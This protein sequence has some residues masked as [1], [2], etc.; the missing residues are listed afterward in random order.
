MKGNRLFVVVV[1]LISFV[2][3]TFVLY[4]P[5]PRF[6]TEQ[7][8]AVRAASYIEAFS[9]EPHSVFD[10]EAH[11]DVRQYL[12][13]TV[14]SFVGE[15]NVT[16][17][18]YTKEEL[19]H[20][21]D[22]GIQN[23]LATIPGE[24]ETGILIVAHYDSRGH[25]GRSGELGRSYGAADDGYGV[26]TM[27][28]IARLYGDQ[29]LQN[30][31]YLLFTDAEETGL[32]GAEM[33]AKE[34]WLMDKVGFVINLEARGVDGPAY[35]FETS[36]N[37]RKV[38][39]FYRQA[40][41]P[42]SY[43][44]A[45]AVYTVMPNSTD[46]TEFLAIGKQGVNFA[47]LKGLYNYH[48]PFD[49]YTA[50]SL[51]SIQHYGS[52]VVP[53]VEAFVNDSAYSSTDAFEDTTNSVFFT[54]LPN[55][56]V[57]YS[58]PLAI[59]LNLL[60][61]AL[62]VAFVI[63]LVL[64]KKCVMMSFLQQLL[65]V[66]AAIAGFAILG[67]FA[68][69]LIAFL[70]KT[71]WSLTYVRMTGSELPTLLILLLTTLVLGGLIETKYAAKDKRTLM[72]AGIF[73]NLFFATLTGFVLSGASFLFFVPAALGLITLVVHE[74]VDKRGIRHFFFAQN[75]LWNLLLL[76]PI[77]YSLFLALTVGGLL[78]LLVILIINLSIVLP[79]VS[80]QLHL[81]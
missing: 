62:F 81:E 35:M 20:G 41:L 65:Y 67:L 12:I 31:I 61:I 47:V 80:L 23:I 3:S 55:V 58:E 7:F 30:S 14:G 45:T 10:A 37:N 60:F 24:S 28:E 27:L 42:V 71:T 33:A 56:F 48:T 36:V 46:F 43:S 17:M 18:N 79:S 39:D 15:A 11:E 32:L 1:V 72:L 53:L 22:Y 40:E 69:R 26:A 68:S 25:I 5:I 38:I 50:I 59:G 21:T 19:G 76:V 51:S 77:L 16:E 73:L 6:S 54:I 74:F 70:G 4:T 52:Q 49:N 9:R 57:A 34:T 63:Y 75:I 66:F 13:E 78:A 29:P 64:K 8:S 44:L 2:L